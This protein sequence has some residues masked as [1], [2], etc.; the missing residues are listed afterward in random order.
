MWWHTGLVLAFTDWHKEGG[1]LVVK[2][3]VRKFLQDNW[4]WKTSCN[5]FSSLY[6]QIAKGPY[7]RRWEAKLNFFDLR[8]CVMFLPI[9][10]WHEHVT[11]RFVLQMVHNLQHT[12]YLKDFWKISSHDYWRMLLEVP[13]PW[14][15][16][17]DLPLHP[18]GAD[19]GVCG[20]Q[21]FWGV[22]RLW[23]AHYP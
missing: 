19:F 23:Q 10:T 21:Q 4:I 12:F 9:S 18:L 17:L 11:L 8:V 22:R 3:K 14:H 13:N 15:Q 16:S 7:A 1:E 20:R 6:C 5:T 2:G